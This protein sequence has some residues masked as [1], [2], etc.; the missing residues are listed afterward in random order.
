MPNASSE[1]SLPWRR[2]R[3]LHA[4]SAAQQCSIDRRGADRPS[5]LPSSKNVQGSW[6]TLHPK[7][8]SRCESRGGGTGI[9]CSRVLEVWACQVAHMVVGSV[10]FV[11][12]DGGWA[13]PV[14]GRESRTDDQ[15]PPP[16]EVSRSPLSQRRTADRPARTGTPTLESDLLKETLSIRRKN[17]KV[18]EVFPPPPLLLWPDQGFQKC[19]LSEWGQWRW[20]WVVIESEWRKSRN[21]VRCRWDSIIWDS[22]SD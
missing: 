21:L 15:H 9:N 20:K 16:C 8:C 17:V 13:P 4:W 7:M 19:F 5:F 2:S 11:D 1:V 12:S 3:H 22:K 18:W 14:G 6:A 10:G